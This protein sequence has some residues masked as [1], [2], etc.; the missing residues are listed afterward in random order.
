MERHRR[1]EMRM[2][3]DPGKVPVEVDDCKGNV[4]KL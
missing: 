3:F 4:A 2:I 1:R